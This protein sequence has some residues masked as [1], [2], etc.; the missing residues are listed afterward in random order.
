MG[1][2]VRIQRHVGVPGDGTRL[3]PREQLERTWLGVAFC[4]KY[5]DQ[6]LQP[7]DPL[8]V[9]QLLHAVHGQPVGFAAICGTPEAARAQAESGQIDLVQCR[10]RKREPQPIGP[11]RFRTAHRTR[12]KKD[13]SG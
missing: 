2:G 9:G 7:R 5:C 10:V 12:N 4:A 11:Q 8:L 3:V 6:R 1:H 13:G